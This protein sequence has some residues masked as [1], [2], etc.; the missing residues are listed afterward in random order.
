MYK[1][2]LIKYPDSSCFWGVI[3]RRCSAIVWGGVQPSCVFGHIRLLY[4]CCAQHLNGA[5][6]LSTLASGSRLGR[7]QPYWKGDTEPH[8][9]GTKF[10]I[11]D[12]FL[13]SHKNKSPL[14]YLWH[15]DQMR[16][17]S[18]SFYFPICMKVPRHVDRP[19]RETA[20]RFY[21]LEIVSDMISAQKKWSSIVIER[22]SI[23]APMMS[24]MRFYRGMVP[25]GKWAPRYK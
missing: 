20:C 2:A 17:A 19:G 7:S 5:P 21:A 25:T 11:Y 24:Y 16:F 4:H 6:C 15:I 1:R 8:S 23:F 10:R 18:L 13:C 22:I 3:Q 14:G 12:L 9:P